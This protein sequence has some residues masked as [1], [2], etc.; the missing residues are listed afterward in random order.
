MSIVISMVAGLGLLAAPLLKDFIP[1]AVYPL[2]PLVILIFVAQ[3]IF[4][5]FIAVIRAEGRSRV[6]T[7]FQLLMSYGSLAVGLVLVLVLGFRVEGLLWGNFLTVV[8]LLPFL[9]YLATRGVGIHVRHLHRTD[10]RELWNYAWPLTLGSVA[11]W[12]LRLSDLFIIGTFW[13]VREVGLY[14]VSY[15]ISAKSIELLVSLFLLSVSPLI[16]STW[17]GEG[18]QATEKVLVMVTR[19]YLIVCL[20]AA[21]GLSVLAFPFVALLTTP[22]Y[23]E[24]YK[25]VGFVV[26]ASFIWGLANIAM[27]GITIGKRA[28]RLGANQIIAAATH[29]GLA[30]LLVPRVGYWVA[31]ITTLIGYTVL[32]ALHTIASRKY[33]TWRF[34][35]RTLG[36]VTAASAVMGLAAW[37]VYGL[38]GV[39]G[40]TSLVYLV[41]S[42]VAAV[43]TYLVC[44]WRL[45]EM[46][47]EERAM[48]LQLLFRWRGKKVEAEFG[49]R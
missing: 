16:Y 11:M 12:G 49:H 37:G 13:T 5:V 40:R 36:N 33:L 22:E 1:P 27:M 29:I 20:P 7:C 9:I 34:P 17:E 42:I 23:Y 21:V 46:K 14:S 48:L 19:V 6:Y 31:A 45:G 26:F 44:L 8:T 10:A 32:L 30:V 18:R 2:V 25:I 3:S 4:S 15:N 43:I 47:Q 39:E 28:R 41:L 24:G 35:F 38:S